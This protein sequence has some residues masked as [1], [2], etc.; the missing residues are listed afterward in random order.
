M[1]DSAGPTPGM[2]IFFDWDKPSTKGPDGVADHVAIVERVEDGYVYT[3]EGNSGDCCRQQR[4]L[5]GHYEIY[6]YGMPEY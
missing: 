3:I 6:G 5:I 1:D 2:I 4:Y